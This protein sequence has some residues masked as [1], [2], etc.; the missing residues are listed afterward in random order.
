M[1][2]DKKKKFFFYVRNVSTFDF[3]TCTYFFA[4]LKLLG[5]YTQVFYYLETC[6]LNEVKKNS[7]NSFLKPF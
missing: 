1:Q 5:E 2:T 6:T 7:F 4:F 3:I